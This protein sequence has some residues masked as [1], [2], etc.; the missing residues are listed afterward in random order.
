MLARVA[1]TKKLGICNYGAT[2]FLRSHSSKGAELVLSWTDK[3]TLPLI[4]LAGR[5][6]CQDTL[7]GASPPQRIKRKAR[8]LAGFSRILRRYLRQTRADQTG[9]LGREDS[10]LRMAV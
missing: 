1:T 8:Q 2:Q 9:W 4:R 3:V 10:N 5:D 6:G 7:K